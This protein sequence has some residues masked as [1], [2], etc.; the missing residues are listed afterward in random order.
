MRYQHA[1]ELKSDNIAIVV[2]TAM[3]PA[4]AK[5]GTRIDVQVSSL[6]DC[7]SLE[8]GILQETLML[9]QDEEVYAVA[10]GPVYRKGFLPTRWS[11]SEG[12]AK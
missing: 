9:G 2:V 8:G 12:G 7:E 11:G 10:Q 5:E 1:S 3:F 6:Y 4:F